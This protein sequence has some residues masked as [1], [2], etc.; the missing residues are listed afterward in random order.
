MIE[1]QTELQRRFHRKKKMLKLKTK[2]KAASGEDREKILYKINRL[3][4]WWTEEC[5][6]QTR[7]TPSAEDLAKKSKKPAAKK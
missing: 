3:S 4:P 2:L 7:Y 5:L 6:T 1:R